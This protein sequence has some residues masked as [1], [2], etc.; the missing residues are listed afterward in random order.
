MIRGVYSFDASDYVK[1]GDRFPDMGDMDRHLVYRLQ[2]AEQG[3][4]IELLVHDFRPWGCPEWVRSDFVIQVKNQDPA[5]NA[6]WREALT[7]AQSAA[8]N[9]IRQVA[10]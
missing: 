8:R 5:V 4:C 6:L 10:A 9:G 1:P 2:G 3:A 7:E